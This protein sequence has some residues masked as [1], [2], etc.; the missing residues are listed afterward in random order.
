MDS[1]IVEVVLDFFNLRIPL[2]P[3]VHHEHAQ[4]IHI[5]S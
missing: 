1:A 5:E 2:E 3:G 4:F